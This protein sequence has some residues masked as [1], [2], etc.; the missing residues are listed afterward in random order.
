MRFLPTSSVCLFSL[1][2][3]PNWKMS[4]RWYKKLFYI[5]QK[6]LRVLCSS[7]V[8]TARWEMGSCYIPPFSL[9]ESFSSFLPHFLGSYLGT[10]GPGRSHCQD[11]GPSWGSTFK[12]LGTWNNIGWAQKASNTSKCT[13]RL[14]GYCLAMV[15][16][17]R[18]FENWIYLNCQSI[19]RTEIWINISCLPISLFHQSLNLNYSEKTTNQLS[20][21]LCDLSFGGNFAIQGNAMV[22]FNWPQ[23]TPCIHICIVLT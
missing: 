20:F 11:F 19:E 14:P 8:R 5:C 12:T 7:S 23:M 4:R 16:H 17:L 1:Y 9:R 13:C 10:A 15:N 18:E 3:Y 2:P 22:N 21:S 6:P